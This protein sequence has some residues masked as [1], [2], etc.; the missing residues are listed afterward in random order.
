[1][2]TVCFDRFKNILELWVKIH[3]YLFIEAINFHW[4]QFFSKISSPPES[5]Q[6]LKWFWNHIHLLIFEWFLNQ[7]FNNQTDLN[8]LLISAFLNFVQMQNNS[9]LLIWNPNSKYLGTLLL[10]LFRIVIN[11]LLMLSLCSFTEWM[12]FVQMPNYYFLRNLIAIWIFLTFDL[13]ISLD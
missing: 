12:Y 1:M 11:Q 8:T 6:L 10:I 3:F 9:Y 5:S 2:C 7:I 13:A 4:S